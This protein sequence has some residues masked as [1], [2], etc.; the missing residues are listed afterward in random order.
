MRRKSIIRLSLTG[1]ILL[2]GAI[3][4]AAEDPSARETDAIDMMQSANQVSVRDGQY[5]QARDMLL[6]GT[7]SIK[8]K[9]ETWEAGMQQWMTGWS[10]ILQLMQLQNN[11]PFS[12]LEAT[13]TTQL[14]NQATKLDELIRGAATLKKQGTDA[15]ALLGALPK[16]ASSTYHNVAAYTPVIDGLGARETDLGTALTSM[17]SLADSKMTAMR[18]IDTDTRVAVVGRLRASLLRTGRYPLEA[19]LKAVQELL[20]AQK[21][22]EPLIAQARKIEN[23]LDKN[24]LNLQIF[25]ATDGIVGARAKCTEINT[26][27]NGVVGATKYVN[28]ARSRINTLC[29]ASESHLQSLTGLG[30]TN[31]QLVAASVE[32]VRGAL[33]T[34]CKGAARPAVQC[35][36]L[37]NLAA[38]QP[39]DFTA[40]DEDHLRFVEYGWGDNFEAA[41]LKGAAQ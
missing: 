8:A 27:L 29:A 33:F 16:P 41:K 34:V 37:A 14:N 31:A 6:T 24:A 21:V 22:V 13:L 28:A 2:V 17:S 12:T 25:H 1:A 9:L 10:T 38:L 30:M 39:A 11:I 26:A 35:D 40:M 7:G 20:D 4:L 18:Q 36:K 32:S 19:S 23:D 3:S 5:L 15:L